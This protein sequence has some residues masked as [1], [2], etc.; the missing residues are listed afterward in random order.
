[1][2]NV[3]HYKTKNLSYLEKMKFS[4]KDFFTV[5]NSFANYIK[6]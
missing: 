5:T 1:M 4:D 3:E 2:I 6:L